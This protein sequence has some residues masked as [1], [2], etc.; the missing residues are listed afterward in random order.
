V[1]ERKRG[2]S[3]WLVRKIEEI[4]ANKVKVGE[5]ECEWFKTTKGV[6]QGCPINPLLFT[7]Y[8]ANMDEMLKKSQAGGSVIGR[9]KVWSLAL[10]DDLVI[11]AKSEREME[12]MMK[13]LR[14]YVRKK[15]LEV[16][17]EKTKMMVFNKR[18]SGNEKEGK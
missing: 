11:V 5:K 15:K 10:A 2:I 16:N 8:V 1:Y 6:R 4:Y 18:N 9:E 17:V 3:E 12:E 7:I 14:K 13:N